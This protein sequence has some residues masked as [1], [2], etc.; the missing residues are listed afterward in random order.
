M[1]LLGKIATFNQ[2]LND[3]CEYNERVDLYF[4]LSILVLQRKTATF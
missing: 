3:V 1:A 4:F 2:N